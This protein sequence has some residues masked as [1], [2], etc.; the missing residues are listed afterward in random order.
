MPEA[1][2]SMLNSYL[3]INTLP[4]TYK[5]NV[6]FTEKPK[7]LTLPIEIMLISP[8]CLEDVMKPLIW[9]AESFAD[10]L[11]QISFF[12]LLL[13]QCFSCLISHTTYDS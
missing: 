9:H 8:P 7:H 3:N 11:T 10:C 12:P 13:P 6:R 4:R 1:A 5:L 2:F